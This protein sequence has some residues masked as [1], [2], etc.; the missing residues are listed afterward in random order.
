M[1]LY[2]DAVRVVTGWHDGPIPWPRARALD[3]RGGS[4]LLVTEELLWR[5][6]PRPRLPCGTGRGALRS[7]GAVVP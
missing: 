5:S 7:R 2:R 6:E 3:C 1:C 4:G